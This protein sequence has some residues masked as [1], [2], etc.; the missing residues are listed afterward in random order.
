VAGL[1]ASGDAL[2]QQQLCVDGHPVRRSDHVTYGG[3]PLVHGLV[4]SSGPACAGRSRQGRQ[5]AVLDAG[6]RP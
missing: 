2:A 4:G 3:V 1:V 6:R 5:R